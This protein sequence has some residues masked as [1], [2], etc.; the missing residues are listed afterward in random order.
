MSCDIHG[1]RCAN[2]NER[3]REGGGERERERGGEREA[4][5]K[6]YPT[7]HRLTDTV[8]ALMTSVRPYV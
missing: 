3:E 1:C 8:D 7:T 6:F 4:L 2:E 5:I